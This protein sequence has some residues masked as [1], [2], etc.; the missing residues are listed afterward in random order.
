MNRLAIKTCH[1]YL[2]RE[3][4]NLHSIAMQKLDL[5]N[6]A[7]CVVKLDSIKFNNSVP[8]C[9]AVCASLNAAQHAPSIW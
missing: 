6:R 3:V 2:A 1:T 8:C 5:L 4:N 9:A 7:I